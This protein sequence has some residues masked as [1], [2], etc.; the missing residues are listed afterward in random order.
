MWETC[1]TYSQKSN[2]ILYITPKNV[3]IKSIE[4]IQIP[5]FNINAGRYKIMIE[6]KYVGCFL[7]IDNTWYAIM[8]LFGSTLNTGYFALTEKNK[9]YYKINLT[10]NDNG[11]IILKDNSN[12]NNK[13]IK[14]TDFKNINKEDFEF[15]LLQ[16]FRNQKLFANAEKKQ[17]IE[18]GI[19]KGLDLFFL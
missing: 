13:T 17:I 8:R 15:G 3:L 7:K 18:E 5:E 6:D 11:D 9:V 2:N 16:T 1:I 12:L 14:I 4:T 10:L 19:K